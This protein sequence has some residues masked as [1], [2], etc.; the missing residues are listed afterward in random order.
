MQRI[1]HATVATTLPTVSS[2]GN[3]GYFEEGAPGD[4]TPSTVVTADFMNGV[5]EE[6][7]YVIE[8]AGLDLDIADNTL[9]YQAIQA[10][11]AAY[12]ATL[13]FVPVGTIIFRGASAAPSG[14][15]F[16]NG[17]AISRTTYATLFAAIGETFGSGDGSTTFN[18]PDLRAKFVRGWAASNPTY[19]AGRVFGSTQ[20]QD[21]LAHAHTITLT[22]AGGFTPAGTI[23]GD[24]SHTH[25]VTI[26]AGGSHTHSGT[27][28][29]GGAHAHSFVWDNNT[30]Y[31]L[32]G[33]N[34]A[35]R[36]IGNSSD[37][38]DTHNTVNLG[39]GQHAHT[40]AIDAAADHIHT[41]TLTGAG[42]HAHSFSG[43]AVAA[44]T[45]PA[46]AASSGGNE[47]RPRNIAL[48]PLIKT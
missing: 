23:T 32:S 41:A 22:S 19:D 9:L 34:N 29:Q 43:T 46:T 6:L 17:A 18:L 8:T 7:C 25:A 26:A 38:N 3:P 5:Q 33:G 13:N 40:L 4:T 36:F 31:A 47:T 44:H 35:A 1:T 11:I 39:G 2:T 12:V 42:A 14:W 30:Q 24:G 37:S 16:C 10:M 28:S 45:H 48:Y 20:E 21:Y 15:L 27:A